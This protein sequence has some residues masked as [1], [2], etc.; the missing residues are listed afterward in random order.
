ITVLPYFLVEGYFVR[1]TL[2][3][4][5]DAAQARYPAVTFARAPALGAHPALAE[6]VVRRA[7]AA[8]PGPADARPGLVL[9][10][11]GSPR[12]PADD[13][14]LAVASQIRTC[15]EFAHVGLGYLDL[16]QP[17]IP[18][19]LS[20]CVGSGADRVIAVPYFI[21]LG[22]HVRDDLPA[23]I[24]AGRAAH[25]AARLLLAEHLGY[26]PLLAAVLAD[27]A[28]EAGATSAILSAE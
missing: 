28:R 21:Q 2:Q 15:G 23:A 12:P 6:L 7:R 9:L 20:A 25:P 19:A 22:G 1:V 26:H 24:E 10:A 18:D 13:P 8:D 5:I 11:H 4:M 27:R 16:Q 3:D 17:S 14:I